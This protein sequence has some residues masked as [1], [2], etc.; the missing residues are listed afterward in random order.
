M[1]APFFVL[2]PAAALLLAG[3]TQQA[4]AYRGSPVCK[5]AESK[6]K[7]YSKVRKQA[8]G[9]ENGAALE[10]MREDCEA[11]QRA[12]AESVRYDQNSLSEPAHPTE[13]PNRRF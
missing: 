4:G 8:G 3:C 1:R 10:A 13:I 12:C 7:Y 11:S 2:F 5:Q 6:C 9:R